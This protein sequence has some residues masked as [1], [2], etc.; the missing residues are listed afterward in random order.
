RRRVRE[1]LAGAG[2]DLLA[3]A[4]GDNMRYLLGW[5]PH[6][7][8]RPCFL[9]IAATG[10]GM[11][12]PALNADE[13]QAHVDLPLEVYTDAEGPLHALDRIIA[14]LALGG[15]RVA[16]VEDTM[17]VD[18]ALLLQERLGG[19]KLVLSEPVLGRL[20]MRKDEHEVEALRRAAA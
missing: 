3:V 16:M 1:A 9:V 8:E 13:V 12:V 18:F 4:P 6:P 17:R 11:L 14:R 19:A 20:R 5:H 7:D 15:A 10:E 2:A